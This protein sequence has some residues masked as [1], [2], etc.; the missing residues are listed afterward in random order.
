MK[1]MIARFAVA[2]VLVATLAACG[3]DPDVAASPSPAASGQPLKFAQ[4]MREHGVDMPDPGSDGKITINSGPG[5]EHTVDDAQ[6]ACRQFAPN[7]GN[8]PDKP[9]PKADQERFLKFAACMRQHGVPMQDPEF[10]GGGVKMRVQA[11][12]GPGNQAKDEAAQK[13]CANLLPAEQQGP[14]PA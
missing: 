14:G 8:G 7:G 12:D 6:Q 4:C 9:M 11:P 3:D 2:A 1:T 13:A 10:E 5:Q